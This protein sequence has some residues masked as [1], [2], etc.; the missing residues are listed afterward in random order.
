MQGAPKPCR[1]PDDA[2]PIFLDIV[3]GAPAHHRRRLG[4]GVSVGAHAVLIG[5]ALLLPILWPAAL[6][7]QRDYVR[8]LLYDPPPPPPLPLPRGSALAPEAR[9]PRPVTSAR[10][11]RAPAL[12]APVEPPHAPEELTPEAGAPESEQWG[13]ATGSDAGVPEG[14]EGGVEGGMVGGV[15]GGVLGGV[16]GGTGDIPLTVEYDYDRPP[17]ILRQT[18]PVYPREAFVQKVE[19]IV[20]VEIL[21]DAGGRVVRARVVRSV[22]LLD[23][24]ALDAVRQWTF[25]PAI[26][27]GRAVATVAE[28]PITFSIY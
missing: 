21:I 23:A 10:G 5:L 17:R 16:I 15:P 9:R 22:P 14:M 13:S 19:G 28:A 18:K 26:K 20:L 27:R 3:A 1:R 6:P 25:A 24:A 8:V 12:T 7:D 2:R 11:P 4:L